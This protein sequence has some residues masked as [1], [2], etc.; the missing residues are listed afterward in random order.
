[1]RAIQMTQPTTTCSMFTNHNL[2][3]PLALIRFPVLLG[4][5]DIALLRFCIAI[6]LLLT[7]LICL[8]RELRDGWRDLARLYEMKYLEAD[9]SNRKSNQPKSQPV[10]PPGQTD[11]HLGLPVQL[12]RQA[13]RSEAR[14]IS[15]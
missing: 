1:M 6:P 8:L 13:F 14:L 12:Y 15:K 4:V 7:V 9:E 5:M 2:A 3:L 10:Q 11:D